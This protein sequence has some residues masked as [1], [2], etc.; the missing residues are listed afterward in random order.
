MTRSLK[1]FGPEFFITAAFVGPGTVITCTSAGINFG[2]ALLWT[3]TFSTITTILMQEMTTRLGLAGGVGLG[4]AL[5]DLLRTKP[6]LFYLCSALVVGAIGIG[7][8]AYQVGNLLGSAVGLQ[9]IAGGEVGWWVLLITAFAGAMLLRMDVRKLTIILGTMVLVMSVFFCIVAVLG[10]MPVGRIVRDALVPSLPQGSLL[11][12]M[13]LIGTTV[14][15]YN[16]FLN[17][18]TVRD[19]YSDS[20]RS[21]TPRL[22]RDLRV[23]LILVIGVGGMISAGILISGWVI[24]SSGL[25][26][27]VTP[28]RIAEALVDRVGPSGRYFFGGG[29]MIAGLS[30]AMTAPLAAAY[31]V[32]EIT[33][34]KLSLE[35]WQF[36][37]VWLAVLV[38]GAGFG[39]A[40]LR[41]IPAIV[42]AQATNGILLPLLIVFLIVVL[43]RSQLLPAEFRNGK[44]ASFAALII[45]AVTLLM[46]YRTFQSLLD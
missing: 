34:R 9:L 32:N 12:A 35:D 23:R 46:A 30:S 33:G 19:L 6:W 4:E 17:A 29:L 39:L 22:L 14:V 44:V 41:P 37:L 11:T 20:S 27:E 10:K 40:G 25:L 36:R 31:A 42:F 26:S 21:Q 18:S 2:S 13:A 16:L 5:R 1:I 7:C 24:S 3:L 28:Y 8:A 38:T 43:S 45:L 15:P